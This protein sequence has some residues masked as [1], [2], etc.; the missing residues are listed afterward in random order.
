[1]AANADKTTD[2][3]QTPGAVA[4]GHPSNGL[5]ARVKK[6]PIKA[7]LGLA[8]MAVV[9]LFGWHLYNNSKNVVIGN[10]TITPKEVNQVSDEIAQYIKK[11]KHVS[12]GKK[13]PHDVARD[14][15][16]LNAA[17]K[18]EADKH[19]V[20][21]TQADIDKTQAN[22]YREYGSK[23]G[24]KR[25]IKIEGITQFTRITSEN[26]TYKAKLEDKIIAKKDIFVVGIIYDT[27][28]VNNSKDPSPKALRAQA[29]KTMQDKFLPLFQRHAS[30]TKI[31]T[32]ADI[33]P[34]TKSS[35]GGDIYFNSMPSTTF[36]LYGCTTAKPCAN[37]IK[38]KPLA[39]LPPAVS[40]QSEIDK[41][42]KV[43]QSTGVI[44]SEAGFIGIMRLEHKTQGSYSS[45]DQ[46]L[47]SY[48]NKYAKGKLLAILSA[49]RHFLGVA[50]RA[51]IHYADLVGGHIGSLVF[52]KAYAN[53]SCTYNSQHYVDID[54]SA[55]DQGGS[56]L[57]GVHLTESRSNAA[58]PIGGGVYIDSQSLP[59][60]HINSGNTNS[61]GNLTF[62]DNCYNSRPDFSQNA[63]S[64][65]SLSYVYA[66]DNSG[67]SYTAI[68]GGTAPSGAT[69]TEANA[70]NVAIG[71]SN[72]WNNGNLNIAGHLTIH[73]HYKT[74]P[75]G[76]AARRHDDG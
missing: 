17:L 5:R 31:A 64:G 71:N 75:P 53:P 13:S 27:P 52:K 33:N 47:K 49:P 29:Y 60:H 65:Y 10:T 46:F 18:N 3:Q 28:Y 42:T 1:M 9:I 72:V 69:I 58:C 74:A 20:K 21:I 61:S 25:F 41:L 39:G 16:I 35:I 30:E 57:Q 8:L 12:F 38:T 62:P 40:T 7:I 73:L 6:F 24:Y 67:D 36:T 48:D 76:L 32:Q 66:T 59:N 19:H 70:A 26:D 4:E 45:W 14:D 22:Q 55:Y 68:V 54:I 11:N 2:S 44:N 63:P 15:L 43:G 51:V 50:A 23:A 37:D 56:S 34:K